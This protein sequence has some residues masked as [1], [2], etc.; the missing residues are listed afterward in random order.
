MA[1]ED[2]VVELFFVI[3]GEVVF[4]L[5][6]DER[7]SAVLQS[8]PVVVEMTPELGERPRVGDKWDGK[9]VIRQEI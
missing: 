8:E 2:G 3:D 9:K 7:L 6:T 5:N 1:N 4:N